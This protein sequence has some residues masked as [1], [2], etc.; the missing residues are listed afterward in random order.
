MRRIIYIFSLFLHIMKRLAFFNF[1]IFTF[2]ISACTGDE[3]L[4]PMLERA[5]AYLP[6]C[7]DSAECVLDSINPAALREGSEQRAFYLLL[8][9]EASNKLYKPLPSDTVFQ[10]VVDYYDR[11]G[12]ANQQMKTYYLMGCI[13][14]DRHEAP[15]A[16]QWYL[17]AVEKADTLA[18]DCDYLTLMKVYGQMAD[19][20]H[21]QLM[22]M[23]EIESYKQFSQYAKKAKNTYQEIRGIEFQLDAYQL[24]GD[25]A[26]VLA[27]TDSV[28]RL[29]LQANMHEAAASVYP[30]AIY[31][32]LTRKDYSKAKQLMDIFE[33]QSGLLDADGNIAERRESYYC[34]K[35]MYY[36][37]INK[38]DSA[39]YYYH[40]SIQFGQEMSAY[41][42]L[43]SVYWK[44]Q[45]MDSVA[46]YSLLYLQ[47]VKDYAA[48]QQQ[49]AMVNVKSLYDYTRQQKIAR[50]KDIEA[51]NARHTLYY[52]LIILFFV[53]LFMTVLFV[54]YK[55]RQAQ[56]KDLLRNYAENLNIEL[57]TLNSD[58][59][60]FKTNKDQYEHQLLSQIHDLENQVGSMSEFMN[61]QRQEE[62]DSELMDSDV[63]K[64]F[65]AKAKGKYGLGKVK[66]SELTQLA[67][68]FKTHL[69]Q[70]Y[71]KLTHHKLSEFE[72]QV[73]FLT[74]LNLSTGEVAVILDSSTSSISNTKARANQKLFN[75]YSGDTLY[76]N[77][78]SINSPI[79]PKKT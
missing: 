34:F 20:Y 3:A 47:A 32:Y 72:L 70:C 30:S 33:H 29:Y 73:A 26:V 78:L 35:G 10:E 31:I 38:L 62:D 23:E 59:N 60:L 57:N 22:P 18:D 17:D 61:Q 42:G 11:H 67:K 12:N 25:T 37:G 8:L 44:E 15:M 13:Y 16:L 7:P 76:K 28:H 36:Q 45:N 4:I 6:D 27:L 41:N 19:I 24:K 55:K 54:W 75:Q 21:S 58:Y 71:Y 52:I 68:A 65:V 79:L 39:K 14:R 9:A 48:T 56:E 5:E 64:F 43:F 63:V 46:K 51:S 66:K 40:R 74:R 77:M 2:F 53:S 49:V 1:L 50:Q 69:P